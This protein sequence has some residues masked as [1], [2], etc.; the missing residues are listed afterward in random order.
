MSGNGMGVA[1]TTEL[2]TRG[3]EQ[4]GR[5][6]A[7]QQEAVAQALL[8]MLCGGHALIEGVPGVA[9][10]LAV[11]TLARFLGLEFRRVQGTPD[12]MPADI[13][14][15]NVFSPKTGDFGFHKGP[16]F[17]QFLLTDEINRM[18]PR[19]QA[20]LLESMEERQVTADGERHQLDECFTVFATQNPVEFEGTYPLP[21]AQLDR[22]LLKIKV[23]YPELADERT[24]LE[25]HHAAHT[26]TGLSDIAIEPIP[27]E[28]LAAARREIRS[29]Q[30][31]GAIFD[32][33]LALVRRTREWPSL[34]LGASPRA[35]ASLLLVAK[36]FA[37]REG[38]DFVIPDDV[39]EAA[40]PVLRHRLTLRPEAELEG[41][42]TDRVV[43]DVLAA[44]Q[45][46]K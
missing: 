29:V 28:L 16:V 21:E 2:F 41:F 9:K 42:D 32:Y 10:T 40:I 7:G 15:T 27:F 12:M 20:A 44:T 38:R 45:V 18:P 23:E 35:S 25:R 8:T 24:V 43:R 33:L 36:A 13:L 19:T 30:V 6:I 46:P 14:G 39:K 34:A 31:E 17:T 37:A 1:A 5:V 11:K 26:G 22:F 4:I 3:Q